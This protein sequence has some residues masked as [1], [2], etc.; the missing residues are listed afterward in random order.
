MLAIES[1]QTL[2]SRRSFE[3]LKP[4]GEQMKSS[5]KHPHIGE[6]APRKG[7]NST[8]GTNKEKKNEN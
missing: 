1:D 3:E 7:E 6:K 8:Q 2:G 4:D 5:N